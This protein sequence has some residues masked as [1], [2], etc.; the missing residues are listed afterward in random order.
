MHHSA[1]SVVICLRAFCTLGR[2]CQHQ[3]SASTYQHQAQGH[4][5]QPQQPTPEV[6]PIT[7][8]HSW[9]TSEP[10]TPVTHPTHATEAISPP[11][12][13]PKPTFGMWG[14][15]GMSCAPRP[16]PRPHVVWVLPGTRGRLLPYVTSSCIKRPLLL[17]K[18]G[19]VLCRGKVGTRA[20][21]GFHNKPLSA[22]AGAPRLPP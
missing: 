12:P 6:T 9:V 4:T 5:P 21:R 17:L 22:Q 20:T 16:P 18:G 14:C 8:P 2:L 11:S 1:L 15:P 13:Y 3:Q 7:A 19:F 10:C